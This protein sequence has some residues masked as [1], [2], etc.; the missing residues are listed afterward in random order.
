MLEFVSTHFSDCVFIAVILL[1]MI[2]TLES[3]VAIPFAMSQQIWADN[4]LSPVFAFLS[5]FIG[6]MIPA[7]FV[8]LIS[9]FI[10]NKTTGFIH[11]KYVAKMQEKYK[12]NFLKL[13]KKESTFQKCCL[14]ATFVAIPLPLTGVYSGSLIAGFTNLKIWQCFI[15][16]LIGDLLS[17]LAI[18]LI[19]I[20][21]ENSVFYI[22]LFSLVFVALYLIISLFLFI[23]RRIKNSRYKN[24]DLN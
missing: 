18:L 12:D 17:C 7:I 22:F 3:K 6:S 16:V 5:A 14:L 21:F 15:S 8:I 11:E 2:P 10:K 1:A 19:C 9:R 4:T 13:G 23:L 24:Q 20:F